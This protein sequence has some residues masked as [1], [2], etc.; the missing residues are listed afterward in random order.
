MPILP[1]SWVRRTGLLVLAL[2][3]T[4]IIPF[5]HRPGLG[6]PPAAPPVELRGTWLTNIDSEIL[7]SRS[8]LEAGL[9]RLAQLNFNTVYP[10][11]WNGGYTLYP[12]A[13]AQSAIGRSLD[14]QPGLQGRDILSEVV[15][16]GHQQGLSVIP[17]FEFGLMAP[18]Q[19]ELARRHPEWLT[20]RRDGSRTWLE[21]KEERVWLNPFHPQVQRLLV[22]L[23]AEVVSR[24]DVDGI[25]LD[26]HFGLPIEFGYDPLTVKLY[27][28]QHQG[29]RP[30]ANFRDPSWMRWRSNQVSALMVQ[31]FEAVKARKPDC[32]V[33]L[34]PNPQEFSYKTFLQDW[35]AWER[36]GLV[37]ELVLQVYR[38]NLKAVEAEL[39]RPEVQ[40]ARR[41]I[42]VGVGL[43]VGLKNRPVPMRRIQ[44]QA[45]AVRAAGFAGMS[46]FFY[47]TLWNRASE[48][49]KQRQAGLQTLFAQPVPRPRLSQQKT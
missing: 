43:L 46:F 13:V 27:Q 17:W 9:Q 21:G 47:E 30:P 4:V 15:T 42:P 34:S 8:N 3:V 1:L 10:T 37:E 11:V 18:A 49:P 19:S 23:V 39:Q 28:Q 35:T 24:Y 40:A 33:T 7:F 25:Q 22:D 36:R 16:Q 2:L 26:D 48:T 29:Q 12:S 31:V 45:Q 5:I 44:E 32:L 20:Q 14:P 41:H 6:A 38:E